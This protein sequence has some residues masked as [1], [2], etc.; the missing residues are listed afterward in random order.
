[1]EE[2]KE[3]IHILARYSDKLHSVDDTVKEHTKMIKTRGKVWC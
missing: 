3:P 1:M 2:T